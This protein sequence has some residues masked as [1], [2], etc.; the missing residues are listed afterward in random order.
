MDLLSI[1]VGQAVK[2]SGIPRDSIWITSKLW[3]N[4]YGE[5]LLQHDLP[6]DQRLDGKLRNLGLSLAHAIL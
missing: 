2:D 4:E 1:G 5:A 3:P 6:A